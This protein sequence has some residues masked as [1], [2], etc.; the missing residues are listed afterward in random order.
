MRLGR[1]KCE[2][3]VTILNARLRARDRGARVL[4]NH[5]FI[6]FEILYILKGKE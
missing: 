3:R 1:G 2:K 6:T 4:F 5:L